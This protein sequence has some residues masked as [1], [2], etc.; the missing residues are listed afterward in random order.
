MSEVP[1][2]ST[3]ATEVHVQ[4]YFWDKRVQCHARAHQTETCSVRT[5]AEKSKLYREST[6]RDSTD[7]NSQRYRGSMD[8]KSTPKCVRHGWQRATRNVP[9]TR[10]ALR[11]PLRV[12]GH[13]RCF[14]RRIEFR[15]TELWI[16]G[17][18]TPVLR[19]LHKKKCRRRRE[20]R[21]K[22]KKRK[23]EEEKEEEEEE[24]EGGKRKEKE[25]EK[26]RRTHV[27]RPAVTNSRMNRSI[28]SC[29]TSS[30]FA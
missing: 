9:G 22:K 25:K 18:L 26:R 7:E 21:K 14:F 29:K 2:Y 4:N 6:D 24:E 30:C 3:P 16:K 15:I 19:V 1:L 13:T 12:P 20:N 17:L 23:R 27:S 5:K 28:V 10:A 11:P 8:G